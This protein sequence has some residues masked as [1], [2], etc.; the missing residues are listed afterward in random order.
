MAAG[1][2]WKLGLFYSGVT[3][4]AWGLLP[5]ALKVMMGWM[6]AYT[7]VWY[8][9]VAAALI[10]GAWLAWNGELPSLSRLG[11]GAR[12]ILLLATAGLIG[13]YVF[14]MLGLTYV[15]P[16]TSQVLI[17][18]APVFLL[19][20]GVFVFRER[21]SGRQWLGLIILIAGM[22]LF[23]HDRL[24]EMTRLEGDLSSG[25]A[26]ILTASVTWA[27]YALAQKYLLRHLT[28]QGILLFIYVA[29]SVVLMPSAEPGAILDLGAWPL[30][31][32]A[33]CSLNTVVAYGSFAEAMRHWEASRISAVIAL[34]PLLT[35]LFAQL[36]DALPTGYRSEETI[37][38]ISLG[39]AILVLSGSAVC[40]LGGSRK[41]ERET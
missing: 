18:T 30:A 19:L 5:I 7:I 21:F 13:N 10:V 9:F 23:F 38:A 22:G 8:R 28:A 6:D 31:V 16:G 34:S 26:M 39:G 40:A 41:T 20:G 32:L 27:A 2:N 29:S 15:S 33:F 35:I 12:M 17:Q 25:A 4:I 14:Y 1:G 11:A 3:T 37:D 24:A 36:F